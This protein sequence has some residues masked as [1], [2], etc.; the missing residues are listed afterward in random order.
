MRISYSESG[1][2]TTLDPAYMYDQMKKTEEKLRTEI[3]EKTI[4][5]TRKQREMKI[6]ARQWK[7]YYYIW[8][9][10]GIWT[11]GPHLYKKDFNIS[12]CCKVTG[13]KSISTFHSAIEA[14]K[15][16]ELIKETEE[17]YLI[18]SDT[19]IGA[20]I[21]DICRLIDYSVRIHKENNIDLLRTYF[22]IRKLYAEEIQA[23]TVR[24]VVKLLDIEDNEANR[25]YVNI[26]FA[27]LEFFELVKI[28]E[29]GTEENSKEMVYSIEKGY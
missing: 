2:D 29:R 28:N 6:T 18:N 10:S 20:S 8:C 15:E 19:M 23:F 21:E 27:I 25:Q 9:N 26:Y 5:K 24:D 14:L 3:I 11:D 4:N 13:I 12:K 7:V 16:K 22:I 1:R 17:E